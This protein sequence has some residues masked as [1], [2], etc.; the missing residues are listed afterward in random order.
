VPCG[1]NQRIPAFPGW[2]VDQT[3]FREGTI[4]LISQKMTKGVTATVSAPNTSFLI[5][6]KIVGNDRQMVMHEPGKGEGK[7]LAADNDVPPHHEH[8]EQ[9]QDQGHNQSP[10]GHSGQQEQ[11][12]RNQVT[13]TV[14]QHKNFDKVFVEHDIPENIPGFHR[15]VPPE[16]NIQQFQGDRRHQET[17]EVFRCLGH[18]IHFHPGDNRDRLIAPAPWPGSP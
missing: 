5:R 15:G 17:E 10:D 7:R 12:K 4:L 16:N 2:A 1:H 14:L 3:S 6:F 13:Q 18:H 9:D 11:D 8:A